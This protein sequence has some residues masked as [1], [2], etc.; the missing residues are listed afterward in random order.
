[1][2]HKT[3]F[4]KMQDA[5]V[6]D[7]CRNYA[8]WTIPY[9]MVEPTKDGKAV[10][11]EGDFQSR[12]ALLVNSLASKLANLL[13]PTVTPFMRI[14]LSDVEREQLKASGVEES[15]LGAILSNL[16]ME[17]SQRVFRNDSFN[18]IILALK[19]LIVTGNA[20][21]YRDSD[22]GRI[23]A[24]SLNDFV[25]KR[26]SS[27]EVLDAIIREKTY[28]EALPEEVRA[29]LDKVGNGRFKGNDAYSKPIYIYTRMLRDTFVGG[30]AS[31]KVWQ[32]VEDVPLPDEM[33]GTY[34]AEFLPWTFP[35]WNL[36][37]GENYGRGLVEEH[38][39]DLAKLSEVSEALTIYEIE[40]LRVVNLVGAGAH[41]NIDE[42]QNS[43]TG[44]YVRADPDAVQAF[45]TGSSNKIQLISGELEQVFNTLARAFMYKGNTRTGERVTAYEI[46]TEALEVESAM[47]GAYSALAESFQL[48]LSYVLLYEV[49]RE[50]MTTLVLN[51]NSRLDINT[52]INA[53]G[54]ASKVQN[55]LQA[56]E[57]GQVAVQLATQID[58][59]IDPAKI[60]DMVFAGRS[61][62]T[63]EFF[64]S[65]KQIREEAE[66]EQQQA[67][68][69]AQM[70]AAEAADNQQQVI[71]G[72]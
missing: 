1:M 32:E 54:R 49:D 50:F 61:V 6:L 48:P 68:A 47:G 52:G 5:L 65:E 40:S 62:D 67:E 60:M 71:E 31:Y 23:T 3:L 72:M 70:E 22:R 2:N 21:V 43:E 36:L 69:I 35:T 46:R 20:A 10:E 17:A 39:G 42:L 56:L 37:S 51:P 41:S 57:E 16:E 7:K 66:A 15:Q 18:Q 25:V 4:G 33:S 24:Y 13:F 59:R 14:H 63:S 38:K 53:L 45:E 11:V 28:Y 27:G 55:L 58:R 12:G 19:H 9:L 44:A 26:A 30:R 29:E 64:K 34:P 8:R